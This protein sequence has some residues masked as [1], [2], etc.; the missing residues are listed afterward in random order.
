MTKW[1]RYYNVGQLLQSTVVH[2][3]IERNGGG[4]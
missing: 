1:G 4:Q 3:A 2:E